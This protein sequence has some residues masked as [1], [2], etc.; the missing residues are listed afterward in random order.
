MA[1]QWGRGGTPL[2]EAN[3]GAR[4]VSRSFRCAVAAAALVV[5]SIVAFI[6]LRPQ[7]APDAEGLASIL[8]G[9]IYFLVAPVLLVAGIGFGVAGLRHGAGGGLVAIAV[10]VLFLVAGGMVAVVSIYLA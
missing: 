5:I 2:L 7:A 9:V 1:S 4:H 3:A 8:L 10:N 6:A